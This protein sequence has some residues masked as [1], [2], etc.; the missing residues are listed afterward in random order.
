MGDTGASRKNNHPSVRDLNIFQPY[1]AR[2]YFEKPPVYMGHA[3]EAF[4]WGFLQVPGLRF[5]GFGLWSRL[6]FHWLQGACRAL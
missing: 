3:M 4:A 5:G 2:S 1:T 6:N